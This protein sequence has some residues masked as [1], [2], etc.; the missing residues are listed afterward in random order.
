M[1]RNRWVSHHWRVT[2][3]C[4]PRAAYGVSVDYDVSARD[5]ATSGR[6]FA[7][8][9][10]QAAADTWC[11]AARRVAR[12]MGRPYRMWA[13]SIGPVWYVNAVIED[14][15]ATGA[16]RHALR[17]WETRNSEQADAAGGAT[18]ATRD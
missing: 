18:Q 11:Q 13:Y 10:S 9:S 16:E 3:S 8:R 7:T 15:P 14:W 1:V 4:V 5:L 2:A 6:A 17:E 12:S